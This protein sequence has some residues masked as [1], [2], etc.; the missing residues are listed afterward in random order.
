MERYPSGIGRK[1]FWQKD[2]VAASAHRAGALLVKRH[3]ERL[4]Q[5]FLK[6]DRG[7]RVLVDMGRNG[8]SATFA[9]AYNVRAQP[10]APISAPCSWEE[11]E[12]GEV[13][14]RSFTLRSMAARLGAL[15]DLWAELSASRQSLREA[16]ER[17]KGL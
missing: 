11:V 5:E 14:P 2:E 3:P 17:L 1:A 9:A 16:G 7:G 13:G 4:T 6:S 12:R 15:G 8:W 10:G